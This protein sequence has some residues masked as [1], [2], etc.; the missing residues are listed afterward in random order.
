MDLDTCTREDLAALDLLRGPLWIF[1]LIPNQR[2]W[3]NRAGLRLW[4]AT[5]VAEWVDRSAP[6]QLSKATMTRMESL[7]RRL[8]QGETPTEVWTFYPDGAA[9]VA[10]ECRLSGIHI[11]E[12]RGEAERLAMLVEARPLDATEISAFERRSHEALRYLG[13]P[14]CLYAA[15]GEALL[16]NPAAIDAFGDPAA[17]GHEV[18]QFLASFVDPA[19]AARIRERVA[20]DEVH[21]ADSL[22][23]TLTGER[24]FDTEVRRAIDPVTG[25]P[26][27]LVTRRDVAE[28]RAHV[29]ALE[30]SRQQIAEQAAALRSLAA[31]VMRVGAGV[32]ALP[33]IGALDRERV[34]AAL[35]ALL[36]HT[37]AGPVRR[38]VV[39]LT[40]TAV[41]DSAAAAALLTLVRVLQLQGVV[42]VLSGIRAALAGAIV[43]SGLDLARVPCFMSLEEALAHDA[44]RSR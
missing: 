31:P 4:H 21:R 13:E 20:V 24:W 15:T 25:K 12:R 17:P 38:V 18:D 23:R 43:T 8:A 10:A 11:A 40:G 35:A 44:P 16:R 36:A 27:L 37:S 29:E 30:R 34:E 3:I 32:L 26:G 2:W 5:S 9:P 42:P 7:A 39:D 1:D 14:V 41:L 28:R 19:T 22:A 33:L 6:Q